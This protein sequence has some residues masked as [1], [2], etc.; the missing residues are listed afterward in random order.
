MILVRRDFGDKDYLCLM[1]EKSDDC[2]YDVLMSY[3]NK[4]LASFI[5]K[6]GATYVRCYRS[7][8]KTIQSS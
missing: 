1:D 7:M 5:C 2:F 4:R 6:G 3:L 8:W